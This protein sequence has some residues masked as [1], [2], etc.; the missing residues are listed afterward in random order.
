MGATVEELSGVADATFGK[1][2]FDAW[3]SAELRDAV[4]ATGRT[5]VVLVGAETHICV[6]LTVISLLQEGFEVAV[7]PDAVGSR[8]MER[9]KLGM[10]RI[11]DAGAVPVHT[12]SVVYEWLGTAEHPEFRAILSLVKAHP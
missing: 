11:R 10:E 2:S 6:S 4:R 5:Q 12:E 1:M 9:H 3:G 8:T 7:C